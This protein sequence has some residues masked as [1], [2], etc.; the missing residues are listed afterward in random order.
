[1]TSGSLVGREREL[2]ELG[3]ALEAAE[4]GRG[5]LVLLAGEPGIGK[6]TLAHAFAAGA[7]GRGA[8]LA[9]GRAWEAGGAPAFWPWVEVLRELFGPADV[10]GEGARAVGAALAVAGE[11]V[12]ELAP[13]DGP[14]PTAL[15][16]AQARFRLFDAVAT[17]LR[18]SAR[19]RPLVVVLDDLHAADPATLSLLQL[20]VR[21][22]S[23]SRI[24]L[25]GTVRDVEARL[26][27]EIAA[28]LARVARESRYLALSR[29]G[30]GEVAAWLD[31]AG[32]D[33][34]HDGGLADLLYQR[35]EGNPLF[36]VETY[37]LLRADPRRGTAA[38]PDGVRDV[39]AARLR[40]LPDGCRRLLE[41]AAALG[42][43]VD[44]A[45][46]AAITGASVDAMRGG[47]SDAV[48]AEVVAEAAPERIV[49]THILIREV[50]HRE[51]SAERRAELHLAAARAL[52]AR[53]ASD[54]AAP[55]TDLVH[56]LFAAGSPEAVA[57]A[58]RAAERASHRLAFEDAV[59]FL[60]RAIAAMPGDD[61]PVRLE[62]L[63]ELAAARI[64]AGLGAGGRAA[65]RAA[66][67]IARRLGEPELLARAAL[68]YG[69]VFVFAE[70]DPVLIDLLEEGL[71]GLPPG[72]SELRARLLARLAAARQPADDPEQPMRIGRDAI[73]MADR[74]AGPATR[75][76]VLQAASSA[77]LY[78]GDPAERV[79]LNRQ[80][81]ELAGRAGEP[82]RVLRAQVRLTFDHLE[83]NDPAAA[84]AAI[85]ACER[86]A[87]ELDHPAYLWQVPLL[88]AMRAV[89]Q[90]RFAE[91]EEL[92]GRARAL[93]EKVDDPN[94][95]LALAG[96]RLGLL[97]A[98]A[99]H[100][101]LEAE[102][103]ELLAVIDRVVDVYFAA[104]CAAMVWARLGR[105][106]R[107]RAE[108]SRLPADIG[109][110][111]GRMMAGWVVEAAAAVG[112][113]ARAASLIDVLRPMVWR[114]LSWGVGSLV[115]EDSLA[116]HLGIAL[117]I[118]GRHDEAIASFEDARVRVETLDAPPLA[119]RLDLDVA[120]ALLRRDLPADRER[121]RAL[122]E[123]A[124]AAADEL[125]LPGIGE[126]A[127]AQLERMA[128]P[129][130]RPSPP[131]VR[132][133]PT[134]VGFS[135][136]RDGDV[137]AVSWG[138][139]VFRIQ[140]SRGM[141][142]LAHL[143]SHPGRE[144]HVTD[145]SAPGGA[146]GHLEDAGEMLDPEAIASYRRRLEEVR[147]E[148]DEAERWNDEGRQARLREEMEFLA[149]EL[150]R[151]VGLGGRRRKAASSSEKARVNVKRRLS[152]AIGKIAEHSPGLG[153]H[154]DWAVKTG[155]FCSY[156]PA[157]E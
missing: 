24:L 52:E 11:I 67:D 42:R 86:L 101:A 30:P 107:V 47:L 139:S 56:H 33:R 85:A 153:A 143:V 111:R 117:S 83:L 105:L 129:P 125:G 35:T 144:F 113:T 6:T 124:Q 3:A 99:R 90:G 92:A 76:D 108:L 154:L 80:L 54:P 78:F 10:T 66:A 84:D 137:W 60:E 128:P 61:S 16:P 39:I 70:V 13:P 20:A 96:N 25:I 156:R 97:L 32:G 98:A 36:L 138:G 150:G 57:W 115:T 19:D 75:L 118:A 103:P 145:L 109:W 116:R 31:A 68:R 74:V 4:A 106:D 62:L 73:A 37:R 146:P 95:A 9:W 28:E 82:T 1:V 58:R 14:P 40:A 41:G 55:L 44:L 102:A 134:A 155:V 88:R 94:R 110:A 12:P 112:D 21:A 45:L 120:A 15:A 132:P 34:A 38:L 79:R 18:W 5:S 49:F 89:M 8:R 65:A 77:M 119:A 46:L 26:S 157:A 122:L 48:R 123:S 72:D 29:L 71:G 2:A 141:Q 63:L 69:D 100:D 131:Q 149:A 7:A 152:H 23:R 126:A 151:A 53:D 135:L 121:A 81:A 87:R 148:L 136:E 133:V 127:A 140:D 114:N 147:E 142:I 91:A 93:A 51:L 59:G 43:S 130:A 64:R 50:I 27:P 17:L 22:V 104:A